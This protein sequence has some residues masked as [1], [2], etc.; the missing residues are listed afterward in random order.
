MTRHYYRG[1]LFE[2]FVAEGCMAS[3]EMDLDVFVSLY[4]TM[5]GV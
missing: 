1:M 4:R 2:T 5:G 3:Y